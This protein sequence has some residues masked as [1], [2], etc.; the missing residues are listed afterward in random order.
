[1]EQQSQQDSLIWGSRP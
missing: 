1:V